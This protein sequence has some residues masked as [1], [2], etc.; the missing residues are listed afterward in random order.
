MTN[1]LNKTS[2]I[3]YFIICILYTCI[4]ICS[5]YQYT[6]NCIGIQK[7]YHIYL[8][9]DSYTHLH[10]LSLTHT[11]LHTYIYN[12]ILCTNNSSVYIYIHIVFLTFSHRPTTGTCVGTWIAVDGAS[13][14]PFFYFFS[15]HDLRAQRW[16]PGMIVNE[17]LRPV[18]PNV[19]RE[20]LMCAA[21]L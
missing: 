13:C 12:T 9:M 4:W 21:F 20:A 5:I 11:H 14:T 18:Q 15:N 10:T 2:N 6:F 17:I 1:K 16:W 7:W 3:Y 19:L 8:H